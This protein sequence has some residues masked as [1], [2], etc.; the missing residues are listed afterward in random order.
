MI[1]VDDH[2]L[3]DLEAFEATF[4]RALGQLASPQHWLDLLQPG[5][6]GPMATDDGVKL[7]V[8]N[9]LRHG[10]FKPWGRSTRWS[11]PATW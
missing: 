6:V 1:E 4:P 8:R 2:P 9:L 7:A 11:T 5:A 3:L 10:G